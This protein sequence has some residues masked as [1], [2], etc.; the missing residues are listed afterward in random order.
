MVFSIEEDTFI[1]MAYFRSGFQNNPGDW[2]YSSEACYEQFTA[3]YPEQEI[4]FTMFVQHQ[5]RVI[6]RFLD[7]GSVCKGKSPGRPKVITPES[8]ANIQEH[9]VRS[10]TKSIRQLSQQVGKYID[11]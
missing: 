2:T 9:I 8:V 3:T 11:I 1:V 4:A 6:A 5:D 10:P 7:T